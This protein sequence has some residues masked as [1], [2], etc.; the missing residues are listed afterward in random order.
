MGLFPVATIWDYT[1]GYTPLGFAGG[2]IM[3]GKPLTYVNML[4]NATVGDLVIAHNGFIGTVVTGNFTEFDHM[5]PTTRLHDN[6]VGSYTG[7]IVSGSPN[8]IS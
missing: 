3:S 7:F 1:V 6:F 8:T 4:P 5:L 2:F